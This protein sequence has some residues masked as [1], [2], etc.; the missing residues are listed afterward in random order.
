MATSPL[1]RQ[2]LA[3]FLPSHELILAFE[4][5][6]AGVKTALPSGVADAQ[7]SADS[8]QAQAAEALSALAELTAALAGAL[9]GLAGGDAAVPPDVYT[10]PLS[11]GT[12]SGQNAERVAISGGT[13]TLSTLSTSGL[14]TSGGQI[15]FPAVQV[16][17][18]G[19]NTLDDYEEGAFAP[20]VIGQTTAGTCVYSTQVGRYTKIGNL[21]SFTFDVT[22]SVHT[23]TGNTLV[24]GLPFASLNVAGL[25]TP[26][27]I[28]QA[29]G[30][31]PGAN[32]LRFAWIAPNSTGLNLYE[33][34]QTTG[35]TTANNPI[36]PTGAF[37]V[38]GRYLT[39]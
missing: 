32:K 39:A 21:V 25:N 5:L 23:G 11:L 7:A 16:P 15:S 13:A 24:T 22:W 1:S 20:T 18:V 36:T 35:I 2:Q 28:V 29:A 12:M 17:S 4:A 6:F 9:Q 37:Y 3:Q 31:I 19:V 30:P 26:V 10:P 14:I 34:D 27:T 38:S 8:A 33:S